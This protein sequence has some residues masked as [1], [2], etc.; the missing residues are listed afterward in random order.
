MRASPIPLRIRSRALAAV[1][2]LVCSTMAGL[3]AAQTDGPAYRV[4]REIRLGGDGRW[5]YITID[6]AG[7]R[8]FI[9]RQTRV[10]VIDPASGR[11]LGEIPRID[12][13]HG[14]ALD[15]TT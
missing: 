2:L 6:T 12:G 8:L 5:D 13:A 9:A 4:V 15:Y 14:V 1:L 7:N 11:L 10:M 3:A